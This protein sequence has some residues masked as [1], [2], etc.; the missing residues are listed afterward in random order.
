MTR[1]SHNSEFNRRLFAGEDDVEV[2]RNE[3]HT[4]VEHLALS[5][6]YFATVHPIKGAMHGTYACGGFGSGVQGLTRVLGP[7]TVTI[8]RQL[9]VREM[10]A[11]LDREGK[12]LTLK[13]DTDFEMF[14][15]MSAA[16]MASAFPPLKVLDSG[17]LELTASLFSQYASAI[18][19]GMGFVWVS[20]LKVKGGIDLD[21]VSPPLWRRLL[22]REGIGRGLPKGDMW[23]SA[24]HH[25]R[26]RVAN[27]GLL[28][29]QYADK[30]YVSLAGLA[31]RAPAD[32]KREFSDLGIEL[33][34]G[35]EARRTSGP[36]SS[37]G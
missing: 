32:R 9:L 19:T 16:F 8:D 13:P 10:Q 2:R 29:D 33:S 3:G 28:N 20:N 18:P 34:M 11:F 6:F 30:L 5:I 23:T 25:M 37:N 27:A 35:R 21:V 24:A 12:Q 4:W 1:R 17:D 31:K 7:T 15:A 22:L 14:D 26:E 36:W